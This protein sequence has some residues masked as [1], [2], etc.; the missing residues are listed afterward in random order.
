MDVVPYPV[1][2]NNRERF[3]H[4]TGFV[5]GMATAQGIKLRLGIDWDGDHH[6]NDQ[7]FHDG[8]HF[9][10]VLYEG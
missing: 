2:W 6:F 9:E 8:P 1:D 10:L 4:F 5:L 3:L 7:H